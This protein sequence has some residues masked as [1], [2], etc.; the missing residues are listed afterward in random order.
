MKKKK[1]IL[2]IMLFI[3]FSIYNCISALSDEID[4]S[5]I[6]PIYNVEKY[7]DE[8]LDSIENQTKTDGVE[9]ICIDDGSTDKSSEILKKHAEKNDKIKVITQ[10]N[11]G[12]SVA[13]N[14][15]LNEAKGKYI[16]FVDSD[17][18]LMPYAI[19][20][21]YIT[22][23]KYNVDVVKLNNSSFTDNQNI[24]VNKYT[25][26]DSNMLVV[27]RGKNQNPFEF[28]KKYNLL[29][30]VWNKFWKREFIERNNLRFKE[31]IR[32]EDILFNWLSFPKLYKMV[33]DNNT[34]YIYRKN[35]QGSIMYNLYR[36][37]VD[38]I[39]NNITIAEELVRNRDF[40]KFDDSDNWIIQCIFSLC[41]NS[42]SRN[43]KI[44]E[45]QKY[46]S[47]KYLDILDSFIEKYDVKV[48]RE[49]Q[50]KM[51]VYRRLANM[52]L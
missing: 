2:S 50:S 32:L 51:N 23:E 27:T 39:E 25:Y 38:R 14:Q 36:N 20:K 33:V 24:D 37:L 18:L 10:E 44:P 52:N 29:N 21:A 40:V 49:N 42:I 11:Q 31:G 46:Y 48:S 8:C 4:V 3:L 17:D 19:E 45:K 16:M 41:Y 30:V 26:K 28:W 1:F 9:I 22:A 47:S 35:R 12:V 43:L 15:G 34:F 5:V 7:L 6:V 13:R